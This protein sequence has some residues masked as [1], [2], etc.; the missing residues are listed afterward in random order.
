M[1]STVRALGFFVKTLAVGV[2]A[3]L[4]SLTVARAAGPPGTESDAHLIRIF[5]PNLKR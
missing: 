1:M 3:G 4:L 5:P 2:T